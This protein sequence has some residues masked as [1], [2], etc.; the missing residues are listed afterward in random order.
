[1]DGIH[2]MGGK[3]GFGPIEFS[4]AE[5][6]GIY[7][8][9][10]TSEGARAWAAAMGTV[11]PDSSRV[12]GFFRFVRECVPPVDYLERPYAEQWLTVTVAMLAFGDVVSMAEITTGRAASKWK[13]HPPLPGSAAEATVRHRDIYDRQIDAAPLY[14]V[15]DAVTANPMG[16]TGHTRLPAYVQGRPGTIHAHHG[17]HILPDT[18]VHGLGEKPTHLYTVEFRA[19]DLWPE[20]A[21]S[22]DKVLLDLWES[23]LTHG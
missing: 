6:L 8:P 15:G 12:G 14:S 4:D 19:A 23:Y 9:F 7:D 2:D 20:R 18:G 10:P 21:E 13:G 11:N 3:H 1:M 5:A 22:N 17:A 16:S